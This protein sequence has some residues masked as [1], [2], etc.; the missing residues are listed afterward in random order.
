MAEETLSLLYL[1]TAFVLGIVHAAEPGHAK[2]LAAAYLVT[3]K[4]TAR[5]AL[6]L[7]LSVAATHSLVVIA[8]ATLGLYFGNGVVPKSSAQ[9]LQ[10]FGSVS[11]VFIG[12]WML[13]Y[14]WPT[15]NLRNTISEGHNSC[16]GCHDHRAKPELGHTEQ[17]SGSHH[18]RC[19]NTLEVIAFGAAGGLAPCPASLSV[20]F[21]ALSVGKTGLGILTVVGFSLGMALAL[22]FV[23]VS[24]VMG[25]NKI[26]KTGKYEWIGKHSSVVSACLVIASGLISFLIH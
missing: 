6:I 10:T 22:V 19:L 7:G 4:G 23:G 8:L 24:V 26:L 14:R 18:P 5:H 16:C 12:L 25:L 21:M 9:H 1:P 17:L 15:R 11:V 13:W 20:M 3:N 2:T